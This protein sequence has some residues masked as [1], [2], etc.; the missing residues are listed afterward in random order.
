MPTDIRRSGWLT[1]G[2]IVL[3][4]AVA[5]AREFDI[6]RSTIDGGGVMRSA[7]GEFD[8]SATVGR[9]DAGVME[10]GE[11]ILTGGFWFEEPPGDC[12]STGGV[13][14]LDYDDFESCLAGP[15][16]GVAEGCAC[17]DM[18]ASGTV[19]LLDFAVAQTSFTGS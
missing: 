5:V 8:L 17:F 10:G 9:P 18:N 11:F 12:N 14:L 16:A 2:V 1:G 7:G 15:D 6:T 19:D 3:V 13:S 4:T